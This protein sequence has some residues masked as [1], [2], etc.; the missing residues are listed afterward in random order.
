MSSSNLTPEQ[1][2]ILEEVL[3]TLTLCENHFRL[4]DRAN[5]ALFLATPKYSPITKA[6]ARTAKSLTAMLDGDQI[7][8]ADE[9]SES[10]ESEPPM[11]PVDQKLE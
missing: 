11:E 6:V 8:S 3:R 10:T 4:R 1:L 9:D 2:D 7:A 5:A